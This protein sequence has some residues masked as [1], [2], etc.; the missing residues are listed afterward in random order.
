[1]SCAFAKEKLRTK[2]AIWVICFMI[3]FREN[4]NKISRS[5]ILFN[6]NLAYG[7]NLMVYAHLTT[8]ASGKIDQHDTSACLQ[9]V[10]LKHLA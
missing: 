2:S 7:L 8:F 9:R 10:F 4:T 5:G 6:A 1:M 3:F